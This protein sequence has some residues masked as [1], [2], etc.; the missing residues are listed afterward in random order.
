MSV[1][2]KEFVKRLYDYIASRSKELQDGTLKLTLTPS[3]VLSLC[4]RKKQYDAAV[5]K[6]TPVLL[7][8]SPLLAA[9]IHSHS[10]LMIPVH[11]RNSPLLLRARQLRPPAAR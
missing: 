8:L 4:K 3:G 6:G 2:G 5:A 10:P 7:R 11:Q 1:S 9:V